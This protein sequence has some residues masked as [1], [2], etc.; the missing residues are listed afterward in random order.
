M[1]TQ[2]DKKRVDNEDN[3][4]EV[5]EKQV[6]SAI[7]YRQPPK[8]YEVTIQADGSA[9]VVT[10]LNAEDMKFLLEF[11]LMQ[12]LGFGYTVNS[13]S[14]FFPSVDEQQ[15]SVLNSLDPESMAKA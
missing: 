3:V 2:E 9:R 10:D 12:L 5:T 15:Q 4:T 1:G 6:I 14:G 13:L 11:G 8:I 7:K